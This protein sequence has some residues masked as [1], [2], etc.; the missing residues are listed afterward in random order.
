LHRH[1][2]FDAIV[3]FDLIGAGGVAW[4][5]GRDLQIPAT[6]WATGGDVRVPASSPHG[7]AVIRALK[8]LDLVFYQSRELLA[9][10]AGLL[11]MSV[12]ELSGN[13]HVVLPRGIPEPPQIC[14]ADTRNRTRATWG[15]K[16]EEMVV[17]Y[18]GRILRQKG[19]LELLEAVDFAVCHDPR[20][21]CVLIGS[22]SALDETALVKQKLQG[23]P[24]SRERV[25]ILPECNPNDIWG[26]LCAG[27]IF[28]FP[29]HHEG[30]PNSLLEAVAIGLPAISFA[31]PAVQELEA[32]SGGVALVPPFDSK[33]LGE[34]ILRLAAS[35]DERMRL[36]Q[37]GRAMVMNKYSVTRNMAA[38]LTSI[39]PLVAKNRSRQGKPV[40]DQP[41]WRN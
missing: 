13:R 14:Q 20:I 41:I 39:N 11:G 33:M 40:E 7:R 6:G 5:L 37:A 17:L 18:L 1:S 2:A 36:G 38:A 30:M 8:N 29:S 12:N 21:R 19:M 27:D 16:A 31:I 32:G 34:A 9:K 23:L 35:P 24:R 26:N 15:V 3:S 25:M 10:A 4:R 28:I 22:N